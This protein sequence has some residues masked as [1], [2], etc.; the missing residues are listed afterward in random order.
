MWLLLLC[1]VAVLLVLLLV[2]VTTP[3]GPRLPQPKGAVPIMGHAR[4]LADTAELT[5]SLGKMA[6]EIDGDYELTVFGM[7]FLVLTSCSSI[8]KLWCDKN[9]RST[10]MDQST[11]FQEAMASL[12][13]KPGILNNLIS[14]IGPNHAHLR[15]MIGPAFSPVAVRRA[16]SLIVGMAERLAGVLVKEVGQ[17]NTR[18]VGSDVLVRCTN[19]FAL[20]VICNLIFALDLNVQH[21]QGTLSNAL[22]ELF[23]AFGRRVLAPFPYWKIYKP[24]GWL[25]DQKVFEIVEDMAL[26]AVERNRSIAEG[27]GNADHL[28][29]RILEAEG[30]GKLDATTIQANAQLLMAAGYDTTAGSMR[31]ALAALATFPECAALVREEVAAD[32]GPDGVLKE[33]SGADTMSRWAYT[34]AFLWEVLRMRPAFPIASGQLVEH[35]DH[36]GVTLPPGTQVFGLLETAGQDNKAYTRAS[37]FEPERWLTPRDEAKYPNH[38]PA[39]FFG[40]S[41]KIC[42]GQHLAKAEALIFIALVASNYSLEIVGLPRGEFPRNFYHF[43]NASAPFDVIFTHRPK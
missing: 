38:H 33:E 35:L 5:R 10:G 31:W 27:I 28:L 2:L 8:S 32:V 9:M 24:Q 1:V 37:S 43:T 12:W 40:G 18:V 30:A 22:E 41:V 19:A 6:R 11:S 3:R 15:R 26:S 16:Q 36:N 39:L 20:D 7:R 23:P 29:A 42:I 14:Q 21:A 4:V 13:R 25:R 34:T 17:S